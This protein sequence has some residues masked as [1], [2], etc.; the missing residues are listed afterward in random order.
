MMLLMYQTAYTGTLVRTPYNP[1]VVQELRGTLEEFKDVF[2]NNFDTG[3]FNSVLDKTA[4][5]ASALRDLRLMAAHPDV[6]LEDLSTIHN[7]LESL[8]FFLDFTKRYIQPFLRDL[9]GV[10]G[11]R[12]AFVN[13]EEAR[14]IKAMKSMF[15]YTFPHNLERLEKVYSELKSCFILLN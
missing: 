3:W 10:S 2:E 11:F 14:T 15:I 9:M 7:G 6:S 5:D 8:A 13:N 1:L 4:F 12:P